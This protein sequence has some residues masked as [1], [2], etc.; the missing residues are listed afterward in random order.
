MDFEDPFGPDAVCESVR[1][2]HPGQIVGIK[3]FSAQ[4]WAVEKVTV[5][6]MCYLHHT[7]LSICHSEG[8]CLIMWGLGNNL[9]RDPEVRNSMKSPEEE[10]PA[11][12]R[13]FAPQYQEDAHV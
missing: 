12:W 6:K 5:N 9:L 2:S 4:V 3:M 13:T 8:F 10:Q 11:S 7:C 1:C